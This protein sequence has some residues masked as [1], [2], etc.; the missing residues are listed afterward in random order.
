M[1]DL[2]R[3]FLTEST[4]NLAKLDNDLVS[5]E[6]HPEETALLN[7]IFRTIHTIKG[8]CGFIGLSRLESVA[9]AAENVLDALR[10]GKLE[11]QSA[12]IGDVLAAVDCIKMILEHLDATEAE[13]EGDDRALIEHLEQ[14]LGSPH[15][16]PP[17]I[18]AP[19]APT[20][21]AAVSPTPVRPAP[22]VERG[23]DGMDRRRRG[24]EDSGGDHTLRVGVVVLD[25]L[26]NLVG[27][28]ALS[29]N[30]LLQLMS[31]NEDTEFAKP[32]QQL[33]RVT[34]D[35]LEAVM[36]TR[37]QPI[38]NVWTKLPRIIRDLGQ[39]SGKK[40]TLECVG[41]ETEL[42][43]QI[44]QAIQDPLTHMIRNSADHGIEHGDVRRA[45]G[46]VEHGTIMLSARHEGGHVVIEISDDGAGIDVQRVKRKAVERGLVRADLAEQMSEQQILRLVFEPGFSTAEQITN[47]SGRGVGMDVVRSNIEAIGGT[48]DL[49][50][51]LGKGTKIRVKIPLT[52]AIIQ[53]L[54]VGTGG[55]TFAVPQIGVVEL[56]RITEEQAHLVEVVHGAKFYRL[57]EALLPLVRLD[58]LLNLRTARSAADCNIIVCQ[59]GDRRFG[60]VVDE[61]FDTQEIVVKPVGRLVKHLTAYAGCTITGDGRVIMIL[62]TTGVGTLA[63]VANRTDDA[64]STNGISR[65]AGLVD[66]EGTDS[67][68]LF[69]GGYPALQAVPL[70][71]VARLEEVAVDA[72]EQADGRFLVQYR[73]ALMPVLP[74]HP[75]MEITARD[76]R[77][78][79]VFSNG[80]Q[81]LGI[82]V[83]D[84]RDI[85]EDHIVLQRSATRAG[86]LGVSVI[87]ERATELVDLD[88]Y[89]REAFGPA[90]HPSLTPARG[91]ERIAA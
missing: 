82:A 32:I 17:S 56:V 16:V 43:R 89:F 3:D 7:S 41:A 30:Q 85:V 49:T 70:S 53:A 84:I 55:E 54:L 9:H 10:S 69:D 5:L 83:E 65:V 21:P 28:L 90:R 25:Q 50:S 14:W 80:E 46:K 31:A 71:R 78:V 68:L 87:A 11:V 36:K 19:M 77:P 29:R 20:P 37:M 79:I 57:R 39:A 18:A 51:T 1:D 76:P 73:G 62:D 61:V 59:I 72:L 40:L 47:I 81:S 4:E 91:Q 74:A 60:L 2:L 42:D 88:W 8:T 64:Q 13:P 27:E 63:H 22:P 44:L 67:V 26:M 86:V 45:A 6:Q 33:N 52:L 66:D 24:D 58:E 15:L 48:V 23:W 38:A 12:V 75:A 34:T 35:L